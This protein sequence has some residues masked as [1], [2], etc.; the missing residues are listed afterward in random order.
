MKSFEDL[1]L[2]ERTVKR[3]HRANCQYTV[4][5]TIIMEDNN[6]SSPD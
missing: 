5:M 6:N 2:K 3:E 1:D 4:R